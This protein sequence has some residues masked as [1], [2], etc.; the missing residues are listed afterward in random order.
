MTT[1]KFTRRTVV[2]G[3]L[4][5]VLLPQ[6][7]WSQ[8]AKRDAEGG[9]G[10]TGIVGLLT[11]F[12]S[13]IVG[14]NYVQTDATTLYSDGFGALEKGALS[15]GHSLTVEAAGASGA[16]IARRVHITH[17]LV[18]KITRVPRRRAAYRRQ[19]RRRPVGERVR[20]F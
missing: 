4:S 12:G 1:S 11:D 20:R 3:G 13:L 16:L 6:I 15:I 10:G 17:P 8:G 5:S 7:A 2:S 19:R 14:G 9:I 18:G